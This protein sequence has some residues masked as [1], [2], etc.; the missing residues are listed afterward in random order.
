VTSYTYD[1]RNLLTRVINPDGKA[2]TYV[3]DSLRRRSSMRDPQ[4]ALTTYGYDAND[5]LVSIVNPQNKITTLG[6]DSAGRKVRVVES[7]GAISTTTYNCP[8]WITKV[9]NRAPGGT[10]VNLFTYTYD[11]VGN[12]TQAA[13]TNGDVTTWV[14]DRT[15]QLARERRSGSVSF[16]VTYTYDNA[17]NRTVQKDSGALTTSTYDA[18]N[19]LSLWQDTSGRTTF[20]YDNDGNPTRKD[21]PAQTVYY[22]WDEDSRLTVG[23]PVAG[24]VTFTYTGEGRRVKKQNPSTTTK[25]IYDFNRLLEETDG[26]G[27]VKEQYTSTLD[28]YGDL[29]SEYDNTTTFY[30]QFDAIGNTDALLNETAT[31]TDRYKQRAFGVAVSHT[32]TTPSPY[33]FV[34]QQNYYHDADLDLFF[35]AARAYDAIS[36]RFVSRDPKGVGAGDANYYRYVKNNPVNVVDPSGLQQQGSDLERQS[37]ANKELYRE[38]MHA[39]T[40]REST[41]AGMG[42]TVQKVQPYG[43]AAIVGVK[44]AIINPYIGVF[45]ALGEAAQG[46][47]RLG[48]ELVENPWQT[49]KDSG[50]QMFTAAVTVDMWVPEKAA[51]TGKTLASGDTQKIGNLAG[52]LWLMTLDPAAG[53]T[54]SLGAIVRKAWTRAERRLPEAIEGAVRS[55]QHLSLDEAKALVRQHH[56]GISKAKSGPTTILPGN[57][58]S[59]QDLETVARKVQKAVNEKVDD[60]IR[61]ADNATTIVIE[62]DRVRKG[63][64]SILHDELEIIRGLDSDARIG[65]RGSLA[66]GKK[67]AHKGNALFDVNDFDVDAFIVSD[68][69]AS[70]FPRNAWFRSGAGVAGLSDVQKRVLQRLRKQFPGMRDEFTL[71]IYTKDEFLTKV[72]GDAYTLID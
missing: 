39:P 34:G 53:E 7:S 26:G 55:G 50:G 40:S 9:E 63:V 68:K 22:T 37:Q 10:L 70:Q 27:S 60:V 11:N 30:H 20:T 25:F 64:A 59:P 31:P 1:V 29:V 49:I 28:E 41:S 54:S 38:F 72:A 4:G 16:D 15:Y 21:T 58:L 36:G 57:Q 71:R 5:R 67:G 33:T 14:Y 19:Q 43:D 48:A 32:G 18:A 12:R 52:T 66:R 45:Q 44:Q 2:I 46:I 47:E 3:Y 13:E 24:A 51:E 42:S 6:Y 17:G 56:V 62:I 61:R 23:Q 69:L 8:G 35:T 65:Y